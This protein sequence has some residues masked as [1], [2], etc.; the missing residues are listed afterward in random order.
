VETVDRE[1]TLASVQRNEATAD[2]EP[3]TL[4]KGEALALAHPSGRRRRR[5]S[6]FDRAQGWVS[7]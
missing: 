3:I 7:S 2:A 6:K 4:P 5:G 1:F